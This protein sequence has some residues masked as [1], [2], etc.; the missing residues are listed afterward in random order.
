[1]YKW[2]ID[3]LNNQIALIVKV[4]RLR[5]K[6][7]QPEFGNEVELSKTHI[8]RIEN[9]DSNIRL[10]T[11]IK[12]CNFLELDYN[13]FFIKMDDGKL[14]KIIIEIQKLEK[15]SVNQKKKKK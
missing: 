15:E 11:M 7:S 4:N 9:G 1:M 10:S 12:I 13:N 5:R 2:T 6:M 8:S 14:E 3:E